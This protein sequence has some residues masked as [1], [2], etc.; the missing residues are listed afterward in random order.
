LKVVQASFREQKVVMQA[1]AHNE[2]EAHHKDKAVEGHSKGK[3]LEVEGRAD[4]KADLGTRHIL[5]RH[6]ATISS[7][8]KS[9]P[10]RWSWR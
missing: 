1:V 9:L 8:R 2:E 10:V 7:L 4:S 6:L 5:D 3:G